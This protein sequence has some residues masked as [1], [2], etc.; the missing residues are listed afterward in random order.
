MLVSKTAAFGTLGAYIKREVFDGLEMASK[1][2]AVL[3]GSG[4]GGVSYYR[5]NHRE[6]VRSHSVI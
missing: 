6:R 1:E 2:N 5:E 4:G 3:Q